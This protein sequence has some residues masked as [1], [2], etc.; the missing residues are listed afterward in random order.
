MAASRVDAKSWRKP[1]PSP[2]VNEEKVTYCGTPG[3]ILAQFH[4]GLCLTEIGERR[5]NRSEVPPPIPKK[6]EPTVSSVCLPIK[7]R[8]SGYAAASKKKKEKKEK[9]RTQVIVLDA[10]PV[11][12]ETPPEDRGRFFPPVSDHTVQWD[13]KNQKVGDEVLSRW[14]T[15][16]HEYFWPGRIAK[17]HEDGTLDVVY[18]DGDF[19]ACK[20]PSRVY[21]KHP[22]ILPPPPPRS[23]CNLNSSDEE[24]GVEDE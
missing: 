15:T 2:L 14:G 24:D 5:R 3:C 19:E 16:D 10:Q 4:P 6:K 18:D 12:D 21:A 13:T 23:G 9:K 1:L 7:K 11:H 17:V 20:N 22:P 8:T